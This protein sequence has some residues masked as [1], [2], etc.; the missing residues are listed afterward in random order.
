MNSVKQPKVGAQKT[1]ADDLWNGHRSGFACL[2]GRPNAGKST[3]T[4]ALVGE[5]VAI[6]SSKPETTRH[7]IRAVVTRSGH[8]LVLIDT[9]GLH[10]PR[11][12]L[13]QRLNDVVRETWSE[14][15]LIGVCFPS[16][17]KIGPG[18][19][20]LVSQIAKLRN[21]PKLVALLTKTDLV[22]PERLR[23]HIEAVV[24]LENKL[25][26]RFEAYVPVSA[27]T[28]DQVDVVLAEFLKLLP[29]GP[30]YY[31]DGKI[32][33]EPVQTLVAELIREAA[34]E[35]LRDELPHSLAVEIDEMNQRVG[36]DENNPLLDIFACLVVER[37][38]QKGIIIGKGGAKLKEIGTAARKQ[39]QALLGTKVHLSLKVKVL[40]DWQRNTKH[41]N[42]LGF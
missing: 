2:V 21:R 16:Q 27:L 28:G 10:R 41:L 25:Q 7:S 35:D 19:E 20:F 15:D 39:I 4:N 42:R 30:A 11:T 22:S 32:T 31:P 12:L 34:L 33:D 3:L 24:A 18:D 36:R 6:T 8:Q 14:V 9:P 29:P 1:S 26:I 38:S 5:K 17:Q 13:G 23:K 37:E 40:K